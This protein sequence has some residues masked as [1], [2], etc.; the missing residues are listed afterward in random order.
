[1]ASKR[2]SPYRIYLVLDPFRAVLP[3]LS[4]I[5]RPLEDVASYL[6]GVEAFY[7]PGT[8]AALFGLQFDRN[9]AERIGADPLIE[10]VA[11]CGLPVIAP[12]ELSEEEYI[13]FFARHLPAY[14]VQ[15]RHVAGATGT[16]SLVHQLAISLQIEADKAEA[17][18]R[19]AAARV[20]QGTDG[21]ETVQIAADTPSITM[22]GRRTARPSSRWELD[23]GDDL[24]DDD[25][26]IEIVT[27]D[28]EPDSD[29]ELVL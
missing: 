13:T 25:E 26:L 16:N 15:V 6:P 14:P 17:A 2:R 22:T 5:V 20:A 12:E 10:L 18:A 24:G 29:W 27:S 9:A 23:L 4:Q 7:D 3:R 28:P 8:N 11:E 19:V 21:H 1:M